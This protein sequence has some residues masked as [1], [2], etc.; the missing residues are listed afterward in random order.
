MPAAFFEPL[1][2]ETVMQKVKNVLGI[3]SEPK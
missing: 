1:S 3:E 2:E